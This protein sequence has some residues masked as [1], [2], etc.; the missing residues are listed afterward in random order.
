MN[1]IEKLK[2]YQRKI[3]SGEIERP[4]HVNPIEKARLNPKS[5]RAA[6]NGK[7]FDCCCVLSV[8]VLS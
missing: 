7:C 4:E 1:R 2:E 5:L 8:V 6:I 3:K